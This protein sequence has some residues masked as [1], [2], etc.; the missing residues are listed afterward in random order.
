MPDDRCPT[1]NLVVV[2]ID[3]AGFE[4]RVGSFDDTFR[5]DLTFFVHS[6]QARRQCATG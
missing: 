2:L 3:F 1:P 6:D 5:G 4:E